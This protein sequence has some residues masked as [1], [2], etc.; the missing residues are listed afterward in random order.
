MRRSTDTF[1]SDILVT[2][3]L[4]FL[5]V[6]GGITAAAQMTPAPTTDT[7]T[8]KVDCSKGKSINK[9]LDDKKNARSLI[10]EIEGMCNENVI[11]TR[12]RVTLRGANPSTDG[13]QAESNVAL[14]DSALW[15]RGAHEVTIENLKLTGGYAGLLATEASTT[16]LRV[17][18][19]RLEGNRTYGALLELALIQAEDTVFT[20][21]GNFNAGVFFGRIECA[22][23]TFSNPLG[24]GALGSARGNVVAQR[25]N[26]ILSASALT[27]GGIELLFGYLGVNDSTI[28]A[29]APGASVSGGQTVFELRRVQVGGPM[30]FLQ[31]SS[32]LLLGVTQT[33]GG[34]A[35]S[36][37]DNSFVKIGD[38]PAP[39]GP[40]TIASTVLGFS[41]QNF[42]NGSLLQ[43]SQI[44][45]NLNCGP[46]AN[47]FCANPANVSGTSN[48]A[49]CPKP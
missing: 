25:S 3:F 39:G 11:V 23:C 42:S 33:P 20:S 1:W 18:N 9:A 41:I 7:A 36:V 19:S 31:S 29:P 47:A 8:V 49:L 26:V 44:N 5:F 2:G 43:T 6:F 28:D 32:A 24:S 10:V 17:V 30:R 40:P 13:I 45:G 35:N 27:G 15:V 37:D 21:N 4:F 14:I 16:H 22:R 12:D 46:G 48:C 34:T 38:A